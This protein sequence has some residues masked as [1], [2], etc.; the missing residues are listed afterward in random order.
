MAK[1][2]LSPEK[3]QPPSEPDLKRPRKKPEVYGPDID[4][5]PDVERSDMDPEDAHEGA[6]EDQVEPTTPPAGPAFDDEPKQG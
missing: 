3:G 1:Q 5:K 6:T 4:R 2:P